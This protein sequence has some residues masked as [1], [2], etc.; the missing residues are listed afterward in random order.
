M[1]VKKIFVT[2]GTGFIGAYLVPYLLERGHEVH[3]LW[4]EDTVKNTLFDANSKRLH[5]IKG[6]IL[7]A[8]LLEHIVAK[9]DEIYHLAAITDITANKEMMFKV[10][11]EGTANLVNAALYVGGVDLMFMSS[12]AALGR[13]EKPMQAKN[14]LIDEHQMWENS[15]EHS[16][17]AISKFRAEC[18][19]WRGIQEGLSALIVNPSLVL[20]AG[21][22]TNGGTTSFFT[23]IY[24]GTNYYPTGGM[25]MVD[26]RDLVR[27]TCQLM[28]LGIRGERFIINAENW[29]YKDFFETIANVFQHKAPEKPLNSF[30]LN[31]ASTF[32]SVWSKVVGRPPSLTKEIINELHFLENSYYNGDKLKQYFEDYEWIPITQSIEETAQSLVKS[33]ETGTTFGILPF[34]E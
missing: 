10:N 34:S 13:I 16:N 15:K 12:T 7:D 6:S 26:V 3:L 14:R 25:G 18:E 20:G 23:R 21:D 2:G 27:I 33:I 8:A 30:M 17:Y 11:V 29:A 4:H 24:K 1:S 31:V 32:E 19:V 9:V 5:I 22:W 28:D